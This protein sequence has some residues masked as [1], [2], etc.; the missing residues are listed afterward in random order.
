[1]MTTRLMITPLLNKLK[2]ENKA[3]IMTEDFNLN[4]KTRASKL[5]SQIIPSQTLLFP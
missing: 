1:M 4:L 3:T 5:S 2:K